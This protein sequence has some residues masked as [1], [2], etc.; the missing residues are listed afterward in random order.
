M[1][2]ICKDCYGPYEIAYEETDDFSKKSQDRYDF[3]KLC[4]NKFNFLILILVR[5]D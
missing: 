1:K 4:N 5:L 2:H 3:Y